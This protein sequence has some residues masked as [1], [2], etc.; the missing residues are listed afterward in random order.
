MGRLLEPLAEL[1][2]PSL[3]LSGT[4]EAAFRVLQGLSRVPSSLLSGLEEEPEVLSNCPLDDVADEGLRI[5]C[6]H[7]L[8]ERLK[9]INE[10]RNPSTTGPTPEIR[11]DDDSMPS[12]QLSEPVDE[13]PAI[14]LLSPVEEV[15]GDTADTAVVPVKKKPTTLHPSRVHGWQPHRLGYW[16][17]CAPMVV[18]FEF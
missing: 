15:E 13:T 7:N 17:I 12:I 9:L 10:A 11:L 3:P 14:Q 16:L 4:D 6:A 8:D 2:K 1:P 5:P 18:L